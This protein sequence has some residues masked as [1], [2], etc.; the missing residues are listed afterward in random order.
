M[1]Q[2]WVRHGTRLKIKEMK[3]LLMD[4]PRSS[5]VAIIHPADLQKELFTDSGAGTLIRRGNKVHI[6]TSIDQFQDV[7]ALN[8]VLIR[9]RQGLDAKAVVDR[10]VQVLRGREFRAYFDEPMEALAVV[11]PS[12]GDTSVAHL[13]TFT[14]TRAG[15]L[16]NVAD[17]VFASIRKDFPKLMWT[18]K[19]DDEN[20]TWFFDK[21]D[22]SLSKNGEVLFFYG[23][24]SSDEVRELMLEFTKHGR[25]MFGDINLES[26][27]HRA[28]KAVSGFTSSMASSMAS[29]AGLQQ[30]RAYSTTANSLRSHRQS[31][32]STRLGTRS[33]A[34]TTNPNPPFGAKNNSNTQ[35][36]KVALIGARGYTGKA[37]IDLFNRHPNIDLRH[38]SSR[39]LAGQKL[40]GYDRKEIT[41]ENLSVEDVRRM[42]E[43]SEIDCWVMALPNGVC[44]PFVDAINSVSGNSLIVD[45]SAD[46]RFDPS[47]TYGLPELVDRSSIAKARRISNPGCYA[48]AAQLGI[49]PLVPHLGGQ[50]TVFGV[51][52]YSG[53]GTKPSPKNDVN[54]LT[55][56]MI[57]YS[58]TDHIHEKEMSTQLG[59]SAAFIPHVAVWFQGITHTINIPLKEEMTSRDIRN[60]YQERYAGERLLKII[61]EA[62][63]VKSI[64]GRHGVEIG[65]FAVHSSGKRV[66]VIATIDNLLKGAAT[67]CLRKRPAVT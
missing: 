39:E 17:N 33:Y 11:L 45:L 55:N 42:E 49:A 60:I 36:S 24:A 29:S 15:W 22:G 20:L 31:K 2:W 9:D 59:I 19:E 37:L 47:W 54:N 57:P 63:L 26:K 25:S 1:T 34:T 62:P 67:Q 48:T 50:P 51:S 64:A 10:Y 35:P 46:Y 3:E 66:V 18:V 32:Q 52:G 28:A 27:L 21:A 65:G 12:A 6:N 23:I 30:A 43:S 58:L 41:Y 4:L 14:I 13:S 38:V 56:N 16:T 5:S 61:G 53:A 7:E 8:E 40:K 44:K